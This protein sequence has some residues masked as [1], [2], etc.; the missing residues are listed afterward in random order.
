MSVYA[1]HYT[2]CADAEAIA[3]GRPNHREYLRGLVESGQLLASGPLV[4]LERDQALLIFRAD[5]PAAVEELL[6]GDPFQRDKLVER[7][8]IVQWNAL[9]GAFAEH[10]G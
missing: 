4:G 6:S 5:S 1:V 3:A 2:Y 9:L 10:A 8:E 7:H